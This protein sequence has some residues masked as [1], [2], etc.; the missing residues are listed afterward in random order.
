MNKSLF[1]NSKKEASKDDG[2][3]FSC[4]SGDDEMNVGFSLV[5]LVV[6]VA[7]RHGSITT[8]IIMLDFSTEE[9]YSYLLLTS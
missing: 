3:V 7:A 1:K 2:I 8:D 5:T 9:N 4:G 6:V